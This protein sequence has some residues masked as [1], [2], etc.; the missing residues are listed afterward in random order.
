VLNTPLA[1]QSPP[2]GAN[3]NGNI[4][5]PQSYSVPAQPIQV[6]RVV[7]AIDPGLVV[8]PNGAALQARGS[9]VMGLSSTLIEQ[10][11]IENGAV[12]Q[13]NFDDYPILRLSQTPPQIDVHFIESDLDPQGMGEPV[14]GPVAAAVANAVFALTGQRLRDLPLQLKS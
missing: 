4:G 14:I 2:I 8:N 1:I 3:P 12:T 6:T 13:Q 11:T 7:I 5:L 9:V 10:V